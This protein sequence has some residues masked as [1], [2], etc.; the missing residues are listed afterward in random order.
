M[1]T[2]AGTEKA[3]AEMSDVELSAIIADH[4][5]TIRQRRYVNGAHLSYLQR[6]LQECRMEQT[7][8][9]CALHN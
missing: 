8:R 9:Q 3:L 1:I 7:D 4:N 2:V 5:H 6:R